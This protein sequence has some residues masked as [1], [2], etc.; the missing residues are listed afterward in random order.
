M[1]HWSVGKWKTDNP[2]TQSACPGHLDFLSCPMVK[3]FSV[4]CYCWCGHN[5]SSGFVSFLFALGVCAACIVGPAYQGFTASGRITIT[6]VA[7]VPVWSHA[8]YAMRTSWKKNCFSSAST[9]TG[10]YSHKWKNAVIW[11]W[12]QKRWIKAVFYLKMG[13]CCLWESL[14]WG[15]G[16]TSIWWGLCLYSLYSICFQN[17]WWVFLFWWRFYE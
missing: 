13:T 10:T 9:A 7:L 12:K 8:L 3:V 11:C 15:W 4:L 5:Q 17:C 2:D 1:G 16:W 14:Y 6:T